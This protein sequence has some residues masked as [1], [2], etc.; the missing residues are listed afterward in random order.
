MDYPKKMNKNSCNPYSL[1]KCQ[2]ALEGFPGSVLVTALAAQ[3]K[4][5]IRVIS[6]FWCWFGIRIKM[7]LQYF[8]SE[9]DSIR[10]A[11]QRRQMWHSNV[12]WF[13]VRLGFTFLSLQWGWQVGGMMDEVCRLSYS[14]NM[15]MSVR[16]SD[17]RQWK[18]LPFYWSNNW[19]NCFN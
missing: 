12:Y 9:A 15:Y 17:Y 18:Y 11:C 7:T 19:C 6:M 16:H 10:G 8:C 2:C 1:I 13:N 5:S 4:G 14:C 3:W